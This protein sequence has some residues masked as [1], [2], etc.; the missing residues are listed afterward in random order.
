MTATAN[1]TVFQVVATPTAAGTLR[2]Q[3]KAGASLT[4]VAGNALITS[5]AI[6]DDTT[7]TVNAPPNLKCQLGVLNL[8]NNNWINPA[9]GNTWA[10][11]DKYRLAFV[12][13]ATTQATSTD[14][15]TYNTFVQGVANSSTL[16]LGSATW[17]VIGSTAT[18]DARDNTSTNPLWNGTGEAV[19]LVD[20]TTNIANNYDNLWYGGINHALNLDERGVLFSTNIFTGSNADGTKDVGSVLGSSSN[21]TIGSTASTGPN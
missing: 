9:T 21:L 12:S 5:S 18:V 20:G 15:T 3:V 1:S 10:L 17:R 19:F 13:R 6:P 16:N 7:I 11:G 8:S 4:D 14:I 2:L